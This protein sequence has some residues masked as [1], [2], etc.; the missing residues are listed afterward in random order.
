MDRAIRD[1]YEVHRAALAHGFNVTLLPRQVMEVEASDG[2]AKTSFSHGI[3]ETS[4]LAAVTYAQDLRMRRDMVSRAGYS[5]P[6]GATFAM[7]GRAESPFEYA[8]NKAGYPVVVKP[9]VGDNTIDVMTGIHDEQAL[10]SAIEYLHTP[11]AERPGH[12]RA[13]YALTELREPGERNGKTTVPDAYRFLVEKQVSGEYLRFLVLDGEVINVL[14]C[15]EGP[16]KSEPG[17]IKDVTEAV[18]KSLKEIAVGA[19]AAIPGIAVAALDIVVKDHTKRTDVDDAKIVEYSER[20]WLEVQHTVSSEL[21]AQMGERILG[22]G[23]GQAVLPGAQ[24]TVAVEFRI[25]GSVHPDYLLRALLEELPK[26]NLKGD[27]TVADPAMGY[28]DGFLQGGP[29]EIALLTEGLLSE[30]IA[31]QRAMLVEERHVVS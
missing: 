22:Y 16:W 31:G 14:L 13:A 28:L 4:T 26:R 30:G 2:S 5:V 6:T 25:D 11:P 24:E 19:V 7:G 10:K 27:A 21:S 23:V 17:Q 18:H 15:P 8:Q 20:P 12:V 1:G 9:A 29:G 3:P